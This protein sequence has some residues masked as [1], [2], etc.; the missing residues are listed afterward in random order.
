MCYSDPSK[1][2]KEIGFECEKKLEDMVK[3]A[4]NFEKTNSGR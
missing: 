2:K 3:D 1:A 4:W